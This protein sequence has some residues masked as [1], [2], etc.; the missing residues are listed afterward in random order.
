MSAFTNLDPQALANKAQLKIQKRKRFEAVFPLLVEE[1][2]T[3]LASENM[4]TE[5]TDWFRRNLDYNTPGGKLNRGLS[6]V[7]TAEILLCTDAATGK[8]SRQLTEPEY[9]KAAILGWCVE[10]LQAYFLV[11]DDMMDASVTRRGQPCWYRVEGV[12][13]IAINDAFMLE[14]AI[15]FLLKKHFRSDPYYGMLL[16][17]FHDVTF[18]TELGQLIDL[19]TAPEDSVDLS[20]FSLQKHH[21]IVVYKTAFYSFY[22]PVALAMRMAGV[23]DESLYKQ[24]LDILL[25]MGEYFQVQDDFLD[26]YGTPEQIGKIGTDIFDNKC[27]WNINVALQNATPQQRQLL[28]DNYGKKDPECEKRV[29]DVFNQSNIDLVARFQKYEAESYEHIN[30]L[31]N[32]LPESQGLRRGI[33][34]SFLEKVYRRSK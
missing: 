30:N 16:E 34:R 10:L 3:Y 19:I 7:D 24:A 2:T 1:L 22:L 32:N 25:P 29:K 33:F 5:A 6:V 13:N 21:L 12:G 28:D 9:L 31:I 27:S 11:A 8:L 26:C 20:K 18:Q 14:A 23:T 15:Y 4:P 17:L